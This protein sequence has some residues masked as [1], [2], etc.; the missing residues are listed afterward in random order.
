MNNFELY[1]PTRYVF[2]SGSIS[3]VGSLIPSGVRV[4]MTYG[5]GS[6][7]NNGVY[8]QVVASLSA[9]GIEYS[10]FGGIEPNPKYETCMKAVE[11]ARAENAGFILSVGGGS[12]L[13][14][15]KFIAAALCYDGADPWDFLTGRAVVKKAIP[16]GDVITLPATGSEMNGNAVIS[17]ISTSEKLAF[18]SEL[19]CPVFSVVD[20][21][22]TFG[23]PRRQTVNGIVDTYVH[24]MEQFATREVNSPAQD[25]S[26]IAIIRTLVAEAPKVLAH[27]NDYNVR[28]NLFWCATLGLN[29]WIAQGVVQDWSTHAVGHE[30]TAFYGIDHAMSLAIVLPR[31][32]KHKFESK[33]VKLAVLAREVW[34]AAGDDSAAAE[35]AISETAA[36]FNSIGMPTELSVYGIDARE[37]SDKISNRFRERGASCGEDGDIDADAVREILLTPPL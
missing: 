19:I 16:V 30:L 6:I 8:D 22:V 20:P 36:F 29:T 2:G 32:W 15:S 37:A 25:L 17:R 9:R 11:K 18:S 3:R 21:T 31:L 34:G 13:D 4:L 33:K 12:V 28:A 35:T 5:G 14:A 1:T 23:L 26:A 27:P 10:E 7:R 24:V